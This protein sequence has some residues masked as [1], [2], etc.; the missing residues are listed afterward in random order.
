[1]KQFPWSSFAL[2]IAWLVAGSG[3]TPSLAAPAFFQR[4][5]ADPNKSY[6]LSVKNGP[7]MI[8]ATSF[9]GPNA[10]REAEELVYELRKDYK[11]PAY[12]HHQSFDFSE[13]VIGRGVDRYG[14]PKRMRHQNRAVIDEVAVLVGDFATIDSA[15]ASK[16]LDQIK[17]MQPNSLAGRSERKTSQSFAELREMHAKLMARSGKQK[18]LGPMRLAFVTKNPLLP[19][20]YFRPQGMDQFV[21][22]LNKQTKYSLLECPG[23]FTVQVASFHGLVAVQTSEELESFADSRL[24]KAALRAKALTIAL[25][26]KGWEAYQ[27]HD[28]KKSIVTVG[29]FNTAPVRQADG[30]LDY[31]PQ[32]QVIIDA[33]KAKPRIRASVVAASHPAA[34]GIQPERLLGIPFDP[35]PIVIEVPKRSIARDYVRRP[36]S[37]R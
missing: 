23:A 13:T 3:P 5:D 19:E 34:G 9:R 35:Q 16:T 11:L 6:E 1:M 4:V 17:S 18:Q 32:V 33:F 21:E 22:K 37:V 8:M 27:F 24:E 25:R 20:E 14:E 36:L 29:N 26:E 31:G 30:T 7:W 2:T 12:I 28:R 10:Q 15:D